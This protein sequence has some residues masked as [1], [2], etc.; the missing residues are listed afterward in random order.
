MFARLLPHAVLAFG[1]WLGSFFRTLGAGGQLGG[2]LVSGSWNRTFWAIRAHDR[3]QGGGAR[4]DSPA[5]LGLDPDGNVMVAE[6]D[7]HNGCDG[8][9]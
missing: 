4:F 2:L 9:D 7:N 6:E 3:G 1:D 5:C 8:G